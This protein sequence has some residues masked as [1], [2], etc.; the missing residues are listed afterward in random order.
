MAISLLGSTIVN[1]THLEKTDI[2]KGLIILGLG[3]ALGGEALKLKV[4]I[5]PL[6]YAAEPE[7]AGPDAA[8]RT[9]TGQAPV[10]ESP[11]WEGYPCDGRM[12]G[13]QHGCPGFKKT[14]QVW[15]KSVG[16]KK[17][18]ES[19]NYTPKKLDNAPDGFPRFVEKCQHKC[20]DG[21]HPPKCSLIETRMDN[22]QWMCIMKSCTNAAGPI[23]APEPN[24]IRAGQWLGWQRVPQGY[25]SLDIETS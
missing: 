3:L 8:L 18:P 14:E 19:F 15:D 11:D 2:M 22:P 12:M 1:P 16:C 7:A 21:N 5:Q 20:M 17:L 6:P 13:L 9:L 10:W 24:E 4:D 23:W 25:W